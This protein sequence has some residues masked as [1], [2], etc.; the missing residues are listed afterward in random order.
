MGFSVIFINNICAHTCA[1][2]CVTSYM[3]SPSPVSLLRTPFLLPY[4]PLFS[5]FVPHSFCYL[6]LLP[7]PSSKASLFKPPATLRDFGVH[8]QSNRW[9][10]HTH[11]FGLILPPSSPQ[12]CLLCPTAHLSSEWKRLCSLFSLGPLFSSWWRFTYE[13]YVGNTFLYCSMYHK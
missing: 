3:F 12:A 10:C 13:E 8:L 7:T 2:V 9:A 5:A 1:R 6:L 11:F 4:Y